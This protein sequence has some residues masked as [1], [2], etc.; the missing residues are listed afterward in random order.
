MSDRRQSITDLI[1][2]PAASYVT[3]FVILV[4]GVVRAGVWAEP[5][6]EALRRVAGDPWSAEAL[7]SAEF[8]ARNWLGPLIAWC[9]RLTSPTA[10]FVLH[11]LLAAGAALAW[12]VVMRREIRGEDLRAS[13]LVLAALPGLALP[14]FWVGNDAVTLLLLAAVVT[15]RRRPALVGLLGILLGLNHFE[16]GVVVLGSLGLWYLLSG[17][18]RVRRTTPAVVGLI[19]L[20]VGR[21][22]QDAAFRGI[23]VG[24]IAS[25]LGINVFDRSDFDGVKSV[26][27]LLPLMAW[28]FL[29]LGTLVLLVASPDR[30]RLAICLGVVAL[31]AIIAFDQ[32]R[33][34]TITAMPVTVVALVESSGPVAEWVR[35]HSRLLVALYLLTPWL[36]LDSW[37]VSGSATPYTLLWIADRLLPGFEL[38]TLPR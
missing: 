34:F 35:R 25:R 14:F 22:M 9:L 28:S 38:S 1:A 4:V 23:G 15:A 5:D 3:P 20:V 17:A 31:P 18:H 29:G 16:H 12:A 27:F 7:T 24:P 11:L 8:R 10:Y 32:T 37:K 30:R 36:W 21:L 19:G 2:R 26:Y 33:V 6:S 13:I